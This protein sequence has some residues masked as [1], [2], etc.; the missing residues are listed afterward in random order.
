VV[1]FSTLYITPGYVIGWLLNLHQFRQRTDPAKYTF[2]IVLSNAFFPI[3]IYLLYKYSNSKFVLVVIFLILAYFIY[4]VSIQRKGDRTSKG[5]QYQDESQRFKRNSILMLIVWVFFSILLLVDIQFGNRQYFAATSYDYTTRI[6]VID[7]ITRTGIP[8]ANPTYY[9]GH[10]EPLTFL[11]YYWYILPSIIDQIGGNLI[12]ARQAMIAGVT[13]TGISVMALIAV[14]LRLRNQNSPKKHWINSIIGIQLLLVGGLDFIPVMLLSLDARI[15]RGILLFDGRVEGWNMPIMSWLNAITWVPN[16]VTAMVACITALVFM[17]NAIDSNR[18]TLLI[19][20][21]IAGFSF[22]SSLGTSVWV[23]LLF[24]VAW[25]IWAVILLLSK[26]H[27]RNFWCLSL[28]GFIGLGLSIPFI[29]GLV[30]SGGNSSSG[31]LPIAFYIRSFTIDAYLPDHIS[32]WLFS[33]INLVFLVPNYI[34]ELGFFFLIGLFWFENRRQYIKIKKQFITME[35]TLVATTAIILSFVYSDLIQI[36]DLGIRGWL[37]CQFILLIWAIDVFQGW[38]KNEPIPSINLIKIAANQLKNKKIFLAFLVI[39]FLTTALEAVAT[40]TWSILVDANIVG[41]PN[42]LSPDTNLGQRTYDARLA[43]EYVNDNL[44][45]DTVVQYNPLIVLD[46]PSGLYGTRQMV[47]ADR[48]AYGVPKEIYKRYQQQIGQIFEN[49]NITLDEIDKLCGQYYIN[50][51]IVSDLDSLWDDLTFIE[52]QRTPLYH[53]Q[54]YAV[55]P[56]GNPTTP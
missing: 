32:H 15:T 33:M 8:P 37:P 19:A 7:A 42:D 17:A 18:N 23:T 11:Y 51:I 5:G 4:L 50:A 46:R 13:W 35:V 29:S 6:S 20:S 28:A 9:P 44:P 55:L 41:F 12:N 25:G 36:N 26:E 2:A 30:S 21:I 31:G 10:P 48:V 14:Y 39:G 34:M 54:Y 49:K 43:Y 27:R 38:Q 24:A 52:Q 53:N 47:I 3:S 1:L 40:R 56:C 22:A 45:K 16:H